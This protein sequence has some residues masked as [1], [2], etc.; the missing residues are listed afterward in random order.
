[1]SEKTNGGIDPVSMKSGF[2][3]FM[4]R[5]GAVRFGSFTLKSGRASP[6]FNT[7]G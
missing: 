6:Y 1:M 2:A 3:E 7:V 4:I 5:S